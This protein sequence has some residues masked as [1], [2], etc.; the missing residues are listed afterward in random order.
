MK[1]KYLYFLN[2]INLLNIKFHFKYIKFKVFILYYYLEMVVQN[3]LLL[4][5]YRIKKIYS[6]ISFVQQKYLKYLFFFF[7]CINIKSYD[8]LSS[9]AKI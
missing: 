4:K 9:M 3:Y 5:Y 8:R 7:F 2:K 6:F 1:K